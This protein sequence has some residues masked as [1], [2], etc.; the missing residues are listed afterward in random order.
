M[1]ATIPAAIPV[2]TPPVGYALFTPKAPMTVKFRVSNKRG[3]SY[4]DNANYTVKCYTTDTGVW[5]SKNDSI[6]QYTGANITWDQYDLNPVC[7]AATTYSTQFSIEYN[8]SDDVNNNTGIDTH[9]WTTKSGSSTP[10]PAGGGGG[11][12]GGGFGAPGENR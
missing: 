10:P 5:G 6:G 2:F 7:Y 1:L 4:F 3:D 9:Y 11:G 8:L 12:A